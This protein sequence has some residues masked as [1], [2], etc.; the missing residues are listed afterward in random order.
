MEDVPSSQIPIVAEV[1]LTSTTWDQA[2]EIKW[3]S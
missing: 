3:E 2:K 1:S